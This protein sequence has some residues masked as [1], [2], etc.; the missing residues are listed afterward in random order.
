MIHQVGPA[1]PLQAGESPAAFKI[2]AQELLHLYEDGPPFTIQRLSELLLEPYKY[3]SR[4]DKLAL[5]I[6][7]L[8]LVTS[9][10]S[11]QGE[12]SPGG[13]PNHAGHALNVDEGGDA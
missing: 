2:R 6:E 4:F 13:L 12:Q 11:T 3:H 7:K 1:R 9:T 10:I 5:A 8:L